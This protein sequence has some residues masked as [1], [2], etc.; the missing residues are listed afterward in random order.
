MAIESALLQSI[1]SNEFK[2]TLLDLSSYSLDDADVILLSQALQT[3]SFVRSL[4]FSG[5]NTFTTDSIKLILSLK[6]INQLYLGHHLS[7]SLEDIRLLAQSQ[8][9]KK[10]N[11]NGCCHGDD[12]AKL[13]SECG[14][15]IEDLSLTHNSIGPEGAKA[16][17]TLPK[18]RK[19]NLLWNSISDEGLMAISENKNIV[20]LNVILNKISSKGIISLSSMSSLETLTIAANPIDDAGLEVLLGLP[21]LESLNLSQCRITDSGAKVLAQLAH[22]DKLYLHQNQITDIGAVILAEHPKLTMLNLSH[23]Q[24]GEIGARKFSENK[25]LLDLD[26]SF[27]ARVPQEAFELFLQNPVLH[28][29]NFFHKSDAISGA[30]RKKLQQNHFVW[31]KSIFNIC[32]TQVGIDI[33]YAVLSYLADIKTVSNCRVEFSQKP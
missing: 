5:K 4:Y 22:L 30:I 14:S 11:L 19:L 10:L 32:D 6:Q 2:E 27:N 29:L 28:R 20:E 1:S 9:L 15:W 24:I 23:N 31:L 8:H 33:S 7:L 17:A 16:L 18:L 21:K 26:L 12:G 25:V 3:N 13:F